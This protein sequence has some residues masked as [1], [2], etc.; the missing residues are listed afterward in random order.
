VRHLPSRN[1]LT[2]R[3]NASHS[4]KLLFLVRG[5]TTKSWGQVTGELRK[6]HSDEFH[7]SRQLLPT[8]LGCW[9]RGIWTGRNI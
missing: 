1:A 2:W 5:S 4:L 8:I 9:N 6:L 3:G 7:H